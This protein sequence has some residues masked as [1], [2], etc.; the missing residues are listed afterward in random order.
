MSVPSPHRRGRTYLF[1]LATLALAFVMA[2]VLS[3][4]GLRL[5]GYGR[6]YVNAFGSFHQRDAELGWRGKP[7]FSGR[8]AQRDF[9]AVV[10]HN[11]AG[12]RRVEAAPDAAVTLPTVYVLG[13]SFV[14]GWGVAQGQVVTDQMQIRLPQYRVQNFGLC[15]SGTVQQYLIFAR[16]IYP[17]L[18]PQEDIVVLAFYGND[19]GD[20]VGRNL[21]GRPYATLVQGEVRLLPPVG[22]TCGHP[23]KNKLKDL[24]YL[25]NLLTYSGD[26]WKSTLEARWRPPPSTPAAARPRVSPSQPTATSNPLTEDCPEVQVTAHYLAAFQ[27]ACQEKQVHFVVT[28]IPGQ[29]ELGENDVLTSEDVSPADQPAYRQAFF[30]ATAALGIRTID[31]L[32]RFLRIK[33]S[34]PD[35]RLT[36]VHDFHWNENGHLAAAEAIVSSLPDQD[37]LRLASRQEAAGRR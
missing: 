21:E 15:G 35:R 5:G 4:V 3:E 32:P 14:W 28:Y 23:L 12:F 27:K 7:A 8:M 37:G 6:S 34:Q 19:F 18:Q 22:K 17:Q 20:N 24:S 2:C 31:L 36:F 30:R 1:R 26:R 10:A 16:Q 13:D 33:E 9:S 11:A 29:A 25:F